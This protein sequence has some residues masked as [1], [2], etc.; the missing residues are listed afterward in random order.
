MGVPADMND[1][2]KKQAI[3]NLVNY[4]TNRSNPRA[5]GSVQSFVRQ[6]KMFF[7]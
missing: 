3:D 1:R 7:A 6:A 5:E 2:A 4:M